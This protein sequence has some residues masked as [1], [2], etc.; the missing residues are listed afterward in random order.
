MTNEMK[1]Q[2]EVMGIEE[3]EAVNGGTV[4]EFADILGAFAKQ[5]VFKVT[6]RVSAH[7]PGINLGIAEGVTSLLKEIGIKADI[8]LGYGGS[9]VGSDKNTYTDVISG[10]SISHGEVLQRIEDA[11][12]HAY[13]YVGID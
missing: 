12:N 10:K 11:V 7:I 9:G 13:K 3:L 2:N 8:S 6:N 5:G 4:G 1:L